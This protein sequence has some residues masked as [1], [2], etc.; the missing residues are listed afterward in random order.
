MSER[1]KKPTRQFIEVGDAHALVELAS[2]GED[3][4]RLLERNL[5]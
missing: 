2:D 1:N 5:S 4:A 3:N